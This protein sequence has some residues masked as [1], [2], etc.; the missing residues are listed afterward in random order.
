MTA[1]G[2]IAVLRAKIEALKQEVA[3]LKVQLRGSGSELPDL[4]PD[5]IRSVFMAKLPPKAA[6][7]MGALRAAYPRT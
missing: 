2:Q 4:P 3:H 5:D 6:A 7:M 1:R